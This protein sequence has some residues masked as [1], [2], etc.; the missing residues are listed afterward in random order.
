MTISRL[1]PMYDPLRNRSSPHLPFIYIGFVKKNDDAQRMGR[2]SIWI[3]ELGGDPDDP[4]SWI[5]ASYA[6]PFAG[7]TDINAIPSYDSDTQ[8]AQQSYG[9]WMVPPDLNNEVAVFFANG[10]TSRAFWFACLYQQNMNHMVPGLAVNVTTEPE[11][12]KHVSPVVE[13]NKSNVG[14]TTSP[15]RPP[16]KPLTEGLSTEGLT[17]DQERG[18]PSTSARREAP[19]KVFGLLSPRGNT[20]HIDDDEQNEFIRLRTRSGTQVM[21]DETT[22]FV[23][24]NSKNGDAWLEISDAGVDIYSANS[25]SIRAQQN[26]NIRADQNIFLDAGANI[27]MSAGQKI[28]MS[29]GN[30]INLST[31]QSL[32]ISVAKDGSIHTL[33]DLKVKADNDLK[34]ESGSDTTLKAGGLQLRD[35]S[36]IQDNCG[37]SRSADVTDAKVPKAKAALDTTS[38]Q[39]GGGFV[40]KHGGGKINTIASRMPTHEPWDGH[41]K[42]NVP[43]PPLED[44]IPESGPQGSGNA[45]NVNPDGTITDSGCS[46]GSANTKPI[47]TENYNAISAASDKVGVPLPTMLA[48]SDMESSHQAGVGAKTSSAK[49]MFQ[50]TDGTWNGMVKQY[51]NLY[52]VSTDSGE[53]YNAN[54]NSLMGAQFI[55][56]NSDILKTKGVANPTPGQLYIMHFM[57][58]GGGPEMIKQAQSNPNADASSLFPAAAAANPTIFHGKSI[59]QV[60]QNL[61]TKADSKANAYASQ[62]GLPSPCERPGAT[63]VNGGV[64]GSAT[65]TGAAAAAGSDNL[66]GKTGGSEVNAFLKA[67]GQSLDST[68]NNWCSAYTN[69]SLNAAGIKGS[70]SNVA[71]SF[72][73]WGQPVSGTPAS[74]DV[75]VLARGHAAG[76]TGGHV[77]IATGNTRVVNGTTQYEIVQGNYG[78]RV[79]KSW[80]AA[81]QSTIRRASTSS[82]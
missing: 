56:N 35:G 43:P 8:V 67:N 71:T 72:L 20:M 19:S 47:A 37:L 60:Y 15:R 66:M 78:N 61:T 77:G 6:S 51:G 24:I 27:S 12:P 25:V 52:N 39:S 55:K 65:A 7:A 2:M 57:G 44:V 34:F 41:P 11:P 46:F 80:E 31:D 9:L 30:D 3:P 70:G 40:W 23:Y 68:K 64:T 69:A 75:L 82:V 21:I 81:S 28:T 16:F 63:P 50:F 79:A 76:E 42:S 14:S 22:G 45:S 48:F 18:S 17:K 62:Q 32:A 13:Y 73:N 4:S 5:I 58:S 29:A 74:G 36:S 54:S 10:D 38:K 1:G 33:N 49:G 26:F 59:G 53:V